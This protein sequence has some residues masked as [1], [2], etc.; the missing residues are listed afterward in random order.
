LQHSLETPFEEARSLPPDAFTSPAI[1][2]LEVERIFDREWHC[3]GRLD[4]FDEPGKYV[5]LQIAD[6][7][8]FAIGDRSAGVRAYAN[9]CRHRS[10]RLLE[11]RGKAGRIVCP[12]HGWTYGTDGALVSA[13]LMAPEFD[14]SKCR[15]PQL[16]VEIWRGWVYV[17]LDRDA[18]PLAP[19]LAAVDEELANYHL[20][21]YRSLFVTEEIWDTNWKCLVENFTEA[22]HVFVAHPDTIEPALPTRLGTYLPGGEG[23]YRF[24]QKKVEGIAFD[25]DKG[26]GCLNPRLS[27]DERHTYPIVG[28]YPAHLMSVSEDRMFWLAL[29]PQ[30][31]GQV[32]VR[33][34]VAAYPGTIADDR[35]DEQAAKIKAVLDAVNA[36]DRGIIEQVFSNM[37]SQFADSGRLCPLELCL[38]EFNQYIARKLCGA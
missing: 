27:D 11:G 23:F 4:E 9:V 24:T 3:I 29:Q 2:R 35:R 19:R 25:V 12:Y 7:A 15:L 28:I 1:L 22:Y 31:V 21:D 32:R 6:E 17:N 10:A 18:P 14:V 34:G 38:W 5:T 26:A 33:W 20:E 8:V 30:G 36:E 37:S 16:G 13:P